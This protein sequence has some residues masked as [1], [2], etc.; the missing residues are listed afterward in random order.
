MEQGFDIVK[1]IKNNPV[2]NFNKEYENKFIQKIKDNFNND[3]QNIFLASFYSYLN[4]DQENDYII[5]LD[6][7][8]KWLGFSRK[9]PAKRL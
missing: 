6:D 8:W 3:E 5:E 4:Y 9:D 7:I 2:K 1:L